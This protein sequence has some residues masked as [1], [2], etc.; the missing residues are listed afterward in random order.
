MRRLRYLRKSVRGRV[1]AFTGLLLATALVVAALALAG[2]TRRSLDS[3]VRAALRDQVR[4]TRLLVEQGQLPGVLEAVGERTGQ[5]Q[6]IDSSGAVIAATP[7]LAQR[8]RLDVSSPPTGETTTD[9]IIDGA[10]IGQ[11]GGTRYL[12]LARPVVSGDGPVVIYALSSLRPADRAVRSLT[13][14][15]LGGIPALLLIATVLIWRAVGRALR[16]VEK[17]RR[18]VEAIDARSLDQRVTAPNSDDEI[19]R[20]AVT[21]NALLDRMD[22]HQERQRRFAADA[23]HEL[24]SPLTSARTQLEIALAYPDRTDWAATGRD[25][26]IELARLETLASDLLQVAKLRAATVGRQDPVAINEILDEE[27]R[28][29]PATGAAVDYTDRGTPLIVTGDRELLVRVI[30]N[31][32]GNAQRHAHSRITVAATSDGETVTVQIANDGP[33]IPADRHDEIFVPFTRLDD[34][35][36]S[37]EGGAG[38]GLAIARRIAQ[39]HGGTLVSEPVA[40]G[41]LFVLRLPAAPPATPSTLSTPAEQSS[42]TPASERVAFGR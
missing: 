35:R 6:V 15:F 39:D 32:L 40:T 7:G 28:A 24:R 3:D 14:A 26:L 37:D 1:T 25:V 21:M 38:L 4:E 33:A 19:D 31:L 11:R 36:S 34:A 8:T 16:P 23:S 42:T 17:M 5:V 18:E 9:V 2:W 41:A 12:L 22:V 13:L 30:R 20:L 27:V 29:Q 10:R